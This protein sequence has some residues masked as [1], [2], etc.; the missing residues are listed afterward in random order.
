MP[1]DVPQT[2]EVTIVG[3]SGSLRR[4]STNTAL[5]RTA[6][7][8]APSDVRVVVQPL[9]DVPLFD[10]DVEAQGH[11]PAVAALRDTVAAADALLLSAPEYNFSVSGVLKNAIDWLS[12]GRPAPID[13]L[14]VALLS[15]AGGSGGQRAQ[16][17]LRV[18]LA[19]NHLD[20][21]DDALQ[22][23]HGRDHIERGRLVGAARRQ[24]LADLLAQVR[25]RA[26][27]H[28]SGT[29]VA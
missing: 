27:T 8:L 10:A 9:H 1:H 20:V 12:R 19:H 28:R 11:P 15:S 21:L 14:P 5:L 24:E 6:V 2:P 16:E 22:L 25:A 4:D 29:R 3:L 23:A 26:L 13:G 17:H 7:E 18:I